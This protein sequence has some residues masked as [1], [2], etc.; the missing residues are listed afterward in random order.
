MIEALNTI[1]IDEFYGLLSKLIQL[2]KMKKLNSNPY[3]R[4]IQAQ[5]DDRNPR[6]DR[7]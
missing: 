7:V 4:N 3:Q 2:F 6:P 1:D 5:Q